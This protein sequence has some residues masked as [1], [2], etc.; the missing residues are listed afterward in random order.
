MVILQFTATSIRRIGVI[1]NNVAARRG[2][3]QIQFFQ[4]WE[5]DAIFCNFNFKEIGIA[6][7]ASFLLTNLS[8]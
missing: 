3:A 2:G 8:P 4:N 7:M 6:K 1:E 5:N